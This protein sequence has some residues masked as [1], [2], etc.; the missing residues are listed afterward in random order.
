M[1]IIHPNEITH[2]LLVLDVG[3]NHTLLQFAEQI[4]DSTIN[5]FI[6]V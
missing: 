6:D 4:L 5:L 3:A 2:H 1:E